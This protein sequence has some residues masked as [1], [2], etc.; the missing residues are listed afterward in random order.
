MNFTFNSLIKNKDFALIGVSPFNSY[1]SLKKIQDII[2]FIDKNFNN[3][4]IFI[5]DKIS[6]YTLKALKYE[7]SRIRYKIRKQDNYLRNKVIKSLEAC[8]IRD[9]KNKI[10]FLSDI[11][12]NPIYISK[13]NLCLDIFN[14]DSE[15]RT[16]CMQTSYWVLNSHKEISN[17]FI[18]KEM[19]EVAVQYF[20]QELPIFLSAPEI[21]GIKSCAFIYYTMPVF[22]N[23]IYKNYNLVSK[24]QEFVIV[25]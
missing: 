10:I 22:L 7:D 18:D 21:L 12:Q 24:F 2:C 23:E 3:F 5:P 17:I 11:K 9:I 25:N 19:E 14:T 13:Y 8:N 1:F 20:L 6:E 15:F 16:G 4:A